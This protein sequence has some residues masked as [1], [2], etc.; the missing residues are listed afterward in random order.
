MRNGPRAT[1]ANVVATVALCLALGGASYAAISVPRNSVGS[2]QVRNGSLRLH[3][4]AMRRVNFTVDVK[5]KNFDVKDK[6]LTFVDDLLDPR[7]RRV[8]QHQGYCIEIVKPWRSQTCT[9]SYGLKRGELHIVGTTG[10]GR[11]AVV[12]G[13]TGVYR[14]AVGRDVPGKP[15][16]GLLPN[17]FELLIPRR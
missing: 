1:Y 14:G 9:E 8:G 7:G 2:K 17:H 3:D 4:V 10:F 16:K 11:G 5:V 15:V 6:V 12:V 13:G